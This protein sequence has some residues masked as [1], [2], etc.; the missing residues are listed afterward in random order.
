MS[1][2]KRIFI[3][4]F[5]TLMFSGDKKKNLFYKNFIRDARTL[6][7]FNLFKIKLL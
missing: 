7:H 6:V 4:L 1:F 2:I 3:F 5:N